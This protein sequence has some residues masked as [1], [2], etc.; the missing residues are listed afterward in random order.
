MPAPDGRPNKPPT[1]A[2]IASREGAT[3]IGSDYLRQ[4]HQCTRCDRVPDPRKRFHPPLKPWP[5]DGSY[6]APNIR[7]SRDGL[8]SA[9]AVALRGRG[10]V[11]ASIDVHPPG[12]CLS[13]PRRSARHRKPCNA[14]CDG[15]RG[16][17]QFG[18]GIGRRVD[19]LA[20]AKVLAAT[21]DAAHMR[22]DHRAAWPVF[23]HIGRIANPHR[24][25]TGV[26]ARINPVGL[27]LGAG[28]NANP[29]RRTG[30]RTRGQVLGHQR[31]RNSRALLHRLRFSARRNQRKCPHQG[32]RQSQPNCSFPG[33]HRSRTP[34]IRNSPTVSD[35]GGNVNL[36]EGAACRRNSA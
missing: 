32:Q 8:S 35:C 25:R 6:L 1:A 19:R 10:G 15:D 21:P 36:Q 7:R 5:Y 12:T 34:H 16:L 29:P 11:F 26:V 20:Q 22:H 24:I 30:G 28:I 31:L 23:L 27:G 2:Q 33:T 17:W 14:A 13:R 9:M 3:S 4:E 18:L